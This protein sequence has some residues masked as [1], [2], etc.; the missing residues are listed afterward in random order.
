MGAAVPVC[1]NGLPGLSTVKSEPHISTNL[2]QKNLAPF[3]VL[4]R[5]GFCG[6]R[7]VLGLAHQAWGR[8]GASRSRV[9]HR[10]G[11]VMLLHLVDRLLCDRHAV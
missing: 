4:A 8:E 1:Q 10:A 5:I 7:V 2:S 3:K 11:L 9:P 6:G